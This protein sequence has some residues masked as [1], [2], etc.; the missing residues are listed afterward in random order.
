MWIKS[1][2]PQDIKKYALMNR[3]FKKKSICEYFYVKKK[4]KIIPNINILKQRMNFQHKFNSIN[5]S[6]F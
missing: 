3:R 1:K 6:I 4:N 5:I 2:I